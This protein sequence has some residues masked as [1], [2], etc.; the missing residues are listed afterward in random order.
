MLA[1]PTNLKPLS[2][3]YL[4]ILANFMKNSSFKASPE[5]GEGPPKVV[6]G[7][8]PSAT[9]DSLLYHYKKI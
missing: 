5:R 8:N 1:K 9:A 3:E 2:G 6:E 7:G 4:L